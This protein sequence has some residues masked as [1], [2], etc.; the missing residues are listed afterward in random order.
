[1]DILNLNDCFNDLEFTESTHTYTRNGEKLPSVSSKIKTFYEPFN[2]KK[3]A[4]LY[5]KKHG[6]KTA[7]VIKMWNKTGEVASAKGTG[8]HDWAEQYAIRIQNPTYAFIDTLT[9]DHMQINCKAFWNELDPKY[10]IAA[11]ELR[12]YHEDFKYAGTADIIL[13]NAETG[14]YVIA[15]Y[16]TNKDL[17]KNYRGKTMKMPFEQ[18]LDCPMSKYEIQL[19]Y[20]QMMLEAKGFEVEDR[21]IIHVDL[22]DTYKLYKTPD[23]SS[24]LISY[25]E[26]KELYDWLS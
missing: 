19:S 9:P 22:K 4:P 12:M 20:Y 7:E 17:F 26:H 16:K 3:I 5:A 2:A 25:H 14:K 15:D 8:F 13:K 23:H 1:M 21:W 10:E 11:L 18:L 24:T 6:L